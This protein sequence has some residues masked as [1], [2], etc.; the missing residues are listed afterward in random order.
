[1]RLTDGD[2]VVF[3][4]DSITDSG[5]SINAPLGYGY[6]NL[7]YNLML[8]KYPEIKI[9]VIN[10]GISGNTVIDLL[11]RWDDDVLSY[12]PT[13]ISILIGIN[14]L[15]KFLG[16]LTLFDPENYYKNLRHLLI[17]TKKILHNVNLIL[18]TPFY[19][20]RN[21]LENGFRAKVLELLPQY[22]E[23]VR[24]L[25]NEFSAIYIDLYDTFKKIVN[26]REPN[27]Y[28]PEPIHPN[29][30]GHMVIAL[31]LLEALEA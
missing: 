26:I 1:M 11:D 9:T 10:S 6:V 8:A 2:I 22:V 17:Y 24:L 30:A 5:K 29:F 14:D 25:S 15:H 28:A 23:K 31:K 27:V 16:G 12:K 18:M 3:A 19:I 7:F 4:G 13:W 21:K 20:S